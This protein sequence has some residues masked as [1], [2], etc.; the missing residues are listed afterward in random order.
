LVLAAGRYPYGQNVQG[1]TVLFIPAAV[2]IVGLAV[3]SSYV[4]FDTRSGF[5]L[6]LAI[7]GLVLSLTLVKD[8]VVTFTRRSVGR[9]EY[10]QLN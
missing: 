10:A 5:S 2:A 6:R 1:L 3:A 8:L 9:A 7:C 4:S